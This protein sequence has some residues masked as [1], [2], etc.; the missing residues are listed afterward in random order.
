[1]YSNRTLELLAV[2]LLDQEIMPVTVVEFQT[3]VRSKGGVL[4]NARACGRETA[5]GQW[6]GWI[7]F[8]GPNGSLRT[9]RE[10][11]QPNYADLEYWATGLTPVYLEGALERTLT[12]PAHPAAVATPRPPAYPGPKPEHHRAAGVP[13]S[14]DAV[15]DPF[16]VY[17]K[18]PEVLAQELRALRGRHLRQI[19]RSYVPVDEREIDLES[20]SDPELAAL[21]MRGVAERSG[22]T[23]SR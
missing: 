22:P 10:T 8:D 3:S 9:A 4:Y 7:E 23:S 11:T 19:I 5:L 14:G 16:S 2:A 1:M 13:T 20:M 6:E 18:S 21:V 17:E 15:L 12:T